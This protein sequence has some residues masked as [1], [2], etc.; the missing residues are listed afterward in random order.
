MSHLF[1][2]GRGDKEPIKPKNLDLIYLQPSPN[3]CEKD[4]LMGSL[5][6]STIVTKVF[7]SFFYYQS[8]THGR[9]CSRLT[10]GA[11]DKGSCTRLCCDRG[12]VTK[13]FYRTWQCNCKFIWDHMNVKCDICNERI[14]EYF[15]K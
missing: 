6:R 8:G 2:R 11:D 15:C 4:I 7:F 1:R 5:G 9:K 10:K 3:Y 14:E 13:L 12:Y